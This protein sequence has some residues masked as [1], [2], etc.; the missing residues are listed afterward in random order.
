[1]FF[2]FD[3]LLLW[4]WYSFTLINVL[5][6][7]CDVFLLRLWCFLLWLMFFTSIVILFYFDPDVSLLWLWSFLLWLQ[8]KW[9]PFSWCDTFCFRSNCNPDVAQILRQHYFRPNFLPDDSESSAI[10][11]IFM[12]YSQQGASMHV[13]II[14]YHWIQYHYVSVFM[15]MR[16]MTHV[17][18]MNYAVICL[19][20]CLIPC[21]SDSMFSSITSR[22]LHGRRRS[23]EANCGTCCPLRSAN[24]N[25]MPL[26][27]LYARG[28][29][30]CIHEN[31]IFIYK[32]LKNNK[33]TI[34]LKFNVSIN[35]LLL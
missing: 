31:L 34:R 1:M 5:Y 8:L 26:T 21:L 27:L 4:F 25:A 16:I 9:Y 23:Q 35:H 15:Y 24:M 10:D 19:I 32:I 11:W 14:M 6:F 12:G 28:T 22:D 30:V 2:Y 29:S 18:L 7:N 17:N 3:I 20:P 33:Q 13:C